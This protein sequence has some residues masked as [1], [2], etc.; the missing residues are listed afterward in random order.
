LNPLGIFLFP[1]IF[2]FILLGLINV[3]LLKIIEYDLFEI[4][5]IKE[6]SFCQRLNMIRIDCSNQKGMLSQLDNS[7]ILRNFC[8]F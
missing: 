1:L 7:I 6:S 4:E 2:S 5:G 8:Y 3:L